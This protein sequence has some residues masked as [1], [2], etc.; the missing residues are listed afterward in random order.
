MTSPKFQL[1]GRKQHGSRL[2]WGIAARFHPAQSTP[3]STQ[4][5][6]NFQPPLN[7]QA[8]SQLQALLQAPRTSHSALFPIVNATC[9]KTRRGHEPCGLLARWHAIAVRSKNTRIRYTR[10]RGAEF[11]LRGHMAP[12]LSQMATRECPMHHP[13]SPPEFLLTP[14]WLPRFYGVH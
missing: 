11:S 12:H 9:W 8:C 14:G 1:H 2:H 7:L 4:G 3:S 5:T 13:Q 10:P 6:P